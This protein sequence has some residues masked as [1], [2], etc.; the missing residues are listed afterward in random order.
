MEVTTR[1]LT[2]FGDFFLL[3]GGEI[4]GSPRGEVSRLDGAVDA[5]ERDARDDRLANDETESLRDP[6]MWRKTEKICFCM[7]GET[8]FSCVSRRCRVS[9]SV[10]EGKLRRKSRGTVVMLSCGEA[11]DC[12]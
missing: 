10:V 1:G 6:F 8:V 7:V 9:L 4:S 11:G 3:Q 5:A 2:D 12:S